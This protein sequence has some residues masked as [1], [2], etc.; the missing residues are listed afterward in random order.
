MLFNI[1]ETDFNDKDINSE[2]NKRLYV[3]DYCLYGIK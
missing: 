3:Y 2:I 1:Y